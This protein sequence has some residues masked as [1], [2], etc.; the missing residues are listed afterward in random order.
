[1]ATQWLTA[2]IG[3]LAILAFARQR[4]LEGDMRLLREVRQSMDDFGLTPKGRQNRRWVV[5]EKA[6]RAG[7]SLDEASD[8]REQRAKRLARDG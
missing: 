4:L 8:L 3:S 5:S 1:M 6:E 7:I 2:D